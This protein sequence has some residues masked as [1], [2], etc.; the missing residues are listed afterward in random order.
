MLI[1]DF[2][3]S[4]KALAVTRDYK[5]LRIDY[6][7]ALGRQLKGCWRTKDVVLHHSRK[8]KNFAQLNTSNPTASYLLRFKGAVMAEDKFAEVFQNPVQSSS[9][10]KS[11]KLKSTDF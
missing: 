3:N 5:A 10:F 8:D 4:V 7:D 2:R 9:D 11:N 6:I 1:F